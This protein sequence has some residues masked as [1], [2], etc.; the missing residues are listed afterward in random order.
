MRSY[1]VAV[2]AAVLLIWG[3]QTAND[4]A[5]RGRT[6]EGKDL[7]DAQLARANNAPERIVGRIEP[8]ALI[9]RPMPTAVA[10]S[11][12][13]RVFVNFPRWGDPVEFTVAQIKDGKPVP[14]P[15]EQINK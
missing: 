12:Q 9:Q 7:D 15:D 6:P 11:R 3:C 13:G 1:V 2:A 4:E 8:A 5:P 10:V 14:F